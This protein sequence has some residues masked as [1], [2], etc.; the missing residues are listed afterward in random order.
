MVHLQNKN[1]FPL[2]IIF[3][4]FYHLDTY[5]QSVS[6]T[7]A[8]QVA[9]EY[10]LYSHAGSAPIFRGNKDDID[11]TKTYSISITGNVPLYIVEMDSGWVLVSSEFATKPILA[12][13]PAGKFPNLEEMPCGMKWLLS[14]YENEI[15]YARD[16]LK[17]K[18]INPLWESQEIETR[19]SQNIQ[20]DS[21]TLER[22]AEV[23]WNQ[24]GNNS[25][26]YTIHCDKAYNKFCPTGINPLACG[27]KY[28]G[29][30]GVAVAQ[31]MWYYQWPHSGKIQ[32][33]SRDIGYNNKIS[34]YYW[35]IIPTD[36]YDTSDLD[37]VDAVAGFLTDCAVAINTNFTDS[38]S[39]SNFTN[40][41][42]ALNNRFHYINGATYNRNSY[43]ST[44]WI[45]ML[46]AEIRSGHPILYRGQNN[47]AGH[48][49]VLFGYDYDNKFRVNWG[50]G[51]HYNNGT[52]SLETLDPNDK[53]NREGYPN[54]Q[55]AILYVRPNY[56]DCNSQ[57]TMNAFNYTEEQFE[58]YHGENIVVSN[59]TFHNQ[60]GVIYSGNSVRLTAG[61][62]IQTG[63]N[64]HIAIRDM[65]CNNSS[66]SLAE[67]N[68]E[69]N[70]LSALQQHT[71]KPSN[72]T[73]LDISVSPNPAKDFINISAQQPISLISIYSITG[74]CILQTKETHINTT[75][76]PQ[77][78]YIIKVQTI[79]GT[80]QQTKLIHI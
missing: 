42:N 21:I 67:S 49:F 3:I 11:T 74:Q 53:D 78:T 57:F 48:A 10:A 26:S 71:T 1:I 7:Q 45:N 41:L 50:W 51:G 2:L 70:E 68:N 47:K 24:N 33:Y 16:S 61:T 18:T 72:S 5:A 17:N 32:N 46:K 14:Y 29:C 9:I 23:H 58:C 36:I 55:M 30:V 44:T 64:V 43:N 19:Y 22:M 6:K 28:V 63:S 54:N 38:G 40:S 13:S 69:N 52:F 34:E 56:P 35:N 79:N 65:H 76:L 77:G 15:K 37:S 39:S 31:F 27:H 25:S 73:L 75:H 12:S 4:I 59:K 20:P 62:H 8:T 80:I 66:R 60:K